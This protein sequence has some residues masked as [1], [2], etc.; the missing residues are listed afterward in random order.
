LAPTTDPGV[1][2]WSTPDDAIIHSDD[3]PSWI[4]PVEGADAEERSTNLDA[5][6]DELSRLDA[7]TD[8][9]SNRRHDAAGVLTAIAPVDVIGARNRDQWF[10]DGIAA[11]DYIDE[12]G[13]EINREVTLATPIEPEGESEWTTPGPIQSRLASTFASGPPQPD[14][15]AFDSDMAADPMQSAREAT[16]ATGSD[17]TLPDTSSVTIAVVDTGVSDALWIEDADGNTR[18]QPSSTNFVADDDPSGVGA[19]EDGNGHGDWVAACYAARN[20]SD[21]RLQGFLPLAKVIGCKA[22]D[23]Q[24]SGSL[25]DIAA[26]I[27]HAADQ[28]ADIINLSLGSFRYSQSIQN[29]LAYAVDQ[30]S[31]PIAAAGNDRQATRWLAFPASSSYVIGV[32]STTVAPPEDALSAYYSNVAPHNGVTDNSSGK[33]AGAGLDVGAPGCKLEAATN[34]VLTGTSMAGPVTGSNVGLYVADGGSTDLETVRE[35]L[36]RTARPIPKASKEEV[37]AG[38]PSA[39]NLLTGTE[40]E[41]DQTDAETSE[42][43]ARG[44]AYEYLSGSWYTKHVV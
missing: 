24:G 2:G 13:I 20:P 8:V 25:S 10:N 35:E 39:A 44:A 26:A 27:R 18:L 23:D 11:L 37:G 1:W 17:V 16:E 41:S 40:P 43:A 36:Q 14:G 19:T 3:R 22:L 12:S 15:V 9:I 42:A 6:E 7:N 33:T 28:G 32:G 5:L 30:G 34:D 21:T 4:I 38:M 29:A 31:I